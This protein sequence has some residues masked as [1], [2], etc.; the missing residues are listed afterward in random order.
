[1]KTNVT[2]L[3]NSMLVFIIVCGSPDL[4][5]RRNE[6]ESFSQATLS[7]AFGWIQ[8]QYAINVLRGRM[9]R[10]FSPRVIGDLARK[11][12]Y[13]AKVFCEEHLNRAYEQQGQLA[14]C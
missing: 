5:R 9:K 10:N 7:I 3:S 1:M 12:P 14:L 13:F 11:D 2:R 8:R 6:D 4:V